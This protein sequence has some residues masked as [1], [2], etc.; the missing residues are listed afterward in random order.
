MK[1]LFFQFI[2]VIVF[3]MKY[4]NCSI[5]LKDVEEITEKGILAKAE[6]QL[7]DAEKA[8]RKEENRR[9]NLE[10]AGLGYIFDPEFK[11]DKSIPDEWL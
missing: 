6:K 9:K 8:K 2:H 1:K 7:E 10:R 11:N 5:Y 4:T 3:L